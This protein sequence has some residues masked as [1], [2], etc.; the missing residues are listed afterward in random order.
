[1]G[2][3]LSMTTGLVSPAFHAFYDDKFQKINPTTNQ[4]VPKSNWQVKCGFQKESAIIQLE[5]QHINNNDNSIKTIVDSI[6]NND[7]AVITWDP[8]DNIDTTQSSQQNDNQSNHNENSTNKD[9]SINK[10]RNN[11]Q[12][13]YKTRSGR[14]VKQPDRYGEYVAHQTYQSST[15]YEPHTEYVNPIVMMSSSDPDT[16]YYHEILQQHDKNDFMDAMELEIN[17]HTSKRHWELIKRTSI[18]KNVRIL[19]CVW[20]MR[21]KRDLITGKVVK[22]KARLNVDGSKRKNGY[23]L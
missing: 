21:R 16:M 12:Q 6:D 10:E 19:P 17:N 3:G 13:Q 1:V 5:N 22:W 8:I 2:L 9:N 20:S 15:T 7:P 23:R 11:M 14:I 18:K 4:Y